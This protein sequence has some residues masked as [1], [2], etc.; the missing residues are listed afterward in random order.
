[1]IF[2][3]GKIATTGGQQKPYIEGTG[4]DAAKGYLARMA[5]LGNPLR[6]IVGAGVGLSEVGTLVVA[7]LEPFDTS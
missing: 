3:R 4:S 5:Y 7:R 1:M 2:S 6:R